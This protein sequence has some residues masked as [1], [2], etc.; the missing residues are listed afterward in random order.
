MHNP[1]E[2]TLAAIEERL[3]TNDAA[4]I[5]MRWP[6]AEK[7][8]PHGNHT[9]D[10]ISE[11]CRHFINDI[12]TKAGRP[13]RLWDNFFFVH[14]GGWDLLVDYTRKDHKRRGY[15]LRCEEKGYSVSEDR[16]YFD[17]SL[18]STVTVK[19]V[20]TTVPSTAMKCITQANIYIVRNY[21]GLYSDANM[22]SL[23]SEIR[24]FL[25][26][27]PDE[28]KELSPQM[29][30]ED[31]YYI[32]MYIRSC[33]EQ[34]EAARN[35]A[36]SAADPDKPL[37][38]DVL[39]VLSGHLGTALTWL[40]LAA[41]LRDSCENLCKLIPSPTIQLLQVRIREAQESPVPAIAPVSLPPVPANFRGRESELALLGRHFGQ[42]GAPFFITGEG[43]CGKTSLAAAFAGRSKGFSGIYAV[44]GE[45]LRSTIASIRFRDM[46]PMSQADTAALYNFNLSRIT[47]YGSQ[48]LIIIDNFDAPHYD[49]T[50]TELLSQP[51]GQSV[52]TA[53]D[54]SSRKASASP[55]PGQT[56]LTNADILEDLMRTGARL[57]FTTRVSAPPQYASLCLSDAEHEMPLQTLLALAR[58]IYTDC[59]WSETDGVL[60]SQII[61]ACGKHV[62]LV[63]LISAALQ[64]QSGFSS[65]EEVLDKLSALQLPLIEGE[66]STRRRPAPV[67][68]VYDLMRGVFTFSSYDEDT[69]QMLRRLSLLSPLGMDQA[70]FMEIA[71]G[72]N[73]DSSVLSL[74]RRTLLRLKSL[75]LVTIDPR[76]AHISMHAVLADVAAS[77]LRPDPVNC[78][79]MIENAIRYYNE[80]NTF[81]YD[82]RHL[83][84]VSEMC[85]RCSLLIGIEDAISSARLSLASSHMEYRLGNY[86]T[87][88]EQSGRAFEMIHSFR[89]PD[90]GNNTAELTDVIKSLPMLLVDTLKAAAHSLVKLGSYDAA[91]EYY[92][93]AISIL[94]EELG[95]E[96]PGTAEAWNDLGVSLLES[97]D[98]QGAMDC[99]LSAFEIQEKHFGTDSLEISS[100]YNNL[101]MV[102]VELGELESAESYYQKSLEISLK[103]YGPRHPSTAISYANLGELFMQIAD[104]E[105]NSGVS[106]ESVPEENYTAGQEEASAANRCEE[107]LAL[108]RQY[109][110][111][112]LEI[113]TAAFGS[114]YPENA[115]TLSNLGILEDMEGNYSAAR[116]DYK[117][118]LRIQ[119]SIAGPDHP[120]CADIL[121]N[122]AVSCIDEAFYTGSEDS[123][124]GAGMT[125]L[126][127]ALEYDSQ[128]LSIA[129]KTLGETHSM[130]EMLAESVAWLR[131]RLG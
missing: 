106:F 74:M 45:D 94:T 12:M 10:G 44:Y 129:R 82:A 48:L 36:S 126:R 87:S 113:H 112:A 127:E 29:K 52:S 96:H 98:L 95:E 68:S 34:Y 56:G 11:T 116:A 32:F 110:N 6:T 51:I 107:H 19:G 35:D 55:I 70:P 125:L 128:A 60:M 78:G 41:L 47:Q 8:L 114:D 18:V 85:Q 21:C 16:H 108:A 80:D 4:S 5:F 84:Q 111:K 9:P 67:S 131:E 101:G 20:I 62:M 15:L 86:G 7:E 57:L 83:E 50:F 115:C 31:R 17:E 42:S 103:F 118:S 75:H 43:A 99:L 73:V 91:Q 24:H 28:E 2:L 1:Y 71:A 40:L 102:C 59:E 30:A 77:D 25:E 3:Y 33:L 81:N 65:M 97:G 130:T 105:M 58:S 66:V 49:R 14:F 46:L 89:I 109:L 100:T 64:Q 22:D 26:T 37:P 119:S 122:M 61:L 79:D 13:N 104:S 54:P 90:D 120:H 93:K 39:D 27:G 92:E 63:E 72:H 23:C 123:P 121:H 117:K 124:G 53:S 69:R 88:L 76:T 38:D